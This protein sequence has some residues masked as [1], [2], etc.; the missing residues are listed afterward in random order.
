MKKGFARWPALALY[1]AL[2]PVGV[3]LRL[4]TDPLRLRRR[5]PVTNWQPVRRPPDS[6]DDARRLA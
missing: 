6:L 5:P 1:A 3:A 4:T 2:V